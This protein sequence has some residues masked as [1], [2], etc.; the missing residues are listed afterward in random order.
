MGAFPETPEFDRIAKAFGWSGDPTKV[1]D[2]AALLPGRQ[3]FCCD[4]L[5][6][7]VHFRLDWSSPADV[8]WKAVAQ[9]VADVLAMGGLPT[10]AVWSVGM[11][12]NWDDAVFAGL[13]RGA[14]AACKA[15]GC[16]IV[17][18][19]TVRT[20]GPGFVSLSLLGTL[21]SKNP[22]TRSGARSGD[23][24]VLAGTPGR[25]A[26]GLEALL[27]GKASLPSLKPL[28]SLHKRPKP[29]LDAAVKLFGAPIHAA[30]DLSDGLSSEA[31]HLA[32]ASAKALVFHGAK[33][34]IPAVL[35]KAAA[36]LGEPDPGRWLWHGGEDHGL[37]A[38]VSPTGVK[39]LPE[40]VRV[41]GH[42]EEGTGVWIELD[43]TRQEVAPLGWVHR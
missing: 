8:G 41:V 39:A 9:N 25:S 29:P 7:G 17:G 42:V 38:T 2:D 40:G 28:A 1:G 11:G 32:R 33:M 16:E 30:I 18:G 24:V 12:E 34:T 14:R 6:E 27:Q 23:L 36:S 19:D 37:L 10:Q 20:R 3:L 15:Y 5:A 22:W 26:A 13:A 43:K 21:R 31:S 35:T 4:A